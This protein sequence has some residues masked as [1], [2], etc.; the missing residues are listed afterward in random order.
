[1]KVARTYHD[2]TAVSE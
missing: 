1:M 2:T